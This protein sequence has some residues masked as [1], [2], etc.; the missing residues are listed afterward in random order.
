M[1]AWQDPGDPDREPEPQQPPRDE[2]RVPVDESAIEQRAPGAGEEDPT[3]RSDAP[4]RAD[5]NVLDAPGIAAEP[6]GDDNIRTGRVTGVMGPAHGTH[7][8]GQGG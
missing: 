5:A 1:H 6:V 3:G 2:D 7:G 4:M 8:Q